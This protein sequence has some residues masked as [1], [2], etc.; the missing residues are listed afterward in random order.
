MDSRGGM[1]TR[2]LWVTRSRAGAISL[3]FRLLLVPSGLVIRPNEVEN[4]AHGSCRTAS[5][6]G[7]RR[8]A[9]LSGARQLYAMRDRRELLHEPVVEQVQLVAVERIRLGPRVRLNDPATNVV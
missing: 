7:A 3:G 2:D 1:R 6:S 8:T 5:L 4:E 9:S